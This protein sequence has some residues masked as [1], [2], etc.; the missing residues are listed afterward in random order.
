M[1]RLLFDL[2]LCSRV[3]VLLYLI[4]VDFAIAWLGVAGDLPAVSVD[5]GV[6]LSSGYGGGEFALRSYD[7]F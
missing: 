2:L 5:V 4:P 1:P 3:Q 6:A 7:S